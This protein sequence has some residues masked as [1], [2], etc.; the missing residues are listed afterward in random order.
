MVIKPMIRNSICLNAHPAGLRIYVQDGIDYI[1][2]QKK[3]TGPKN[4]LIVGGSAG[5]GLATRIAAAFGAGAKTLSIAFEKPA[6][7]RRA[8]TAGWYASEYFKT[9][10]EAQGLFTE[11]IYGDAFSREIK[12]EAI[13]A[14]KKHFGGK[15]DLL[16]YSLASGVRTDPR[17]GV[18]YRSVLKPIGAAYSAKSVNPLTGQL[19]EGSISPATEE[20]IEA[21]IKVMGG[22][23][24]E[25]WVDALLEAGVLSQGAVSLAY[26]YIGPD[27]TR[28]V[29]RD[30]TIGRAKEHI[31]NSAKVLDKKL[32]SSL[33]G[34]AYIS[35]NKALV[36][37][38][39]A[40]IPVVP[41]YLGILFKTMEKK[42]LQED[43]I[44]QMYR[45]MTDRLYAGGSV[46]T[47]AEGR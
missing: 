39:S 20:E 17:T 6:S 37:R 7:D 27:M 18:V 43:C 34:A 38:A 33:G 15:V 3:F 25:L 26:S 42:G 11:N 14:V 21:T 16:V 32:K 22:E 35:V 5:Y 36:T 47:D 12:D 46:P 29:Y 10:A 31:E 28:A 41:L 9:Q 13:A 1:K 23:D 44:E 4:V 45:L 30:G 24:W 8:A 19:E 40:V 2:K